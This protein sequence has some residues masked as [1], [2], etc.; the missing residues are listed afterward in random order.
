MPPKTDWQAFY[1]NTKDAPPSPLLVKALAFVKRKGK[2][3]DIGG[4]ALK[5]TRYL[6]GQG[7]GV[8]VIDREGA[9][10]DMA[11]ALD[12]P[13]LRYN[14][15]SFADFDF[16]EGKYDLASAMYALPFNPP[17]TFDAVFENIKK[18]LAKDGI[19]CGNCF[20]VRDQWAA[21]PKMTFHEK[22]HVERLLADME[23]VSLEEREWDGKTADGAPKHWHVI[24]FIAKRP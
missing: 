6:L 8:T 3:I 14:V 21:N 13:Q 24:E 7:F 2:A 19:F 20:G 12:S 23:I 5:D 4:G 18:S 15:T 22:G 16:P 11:A 9:L 10:A 1:R 17:E